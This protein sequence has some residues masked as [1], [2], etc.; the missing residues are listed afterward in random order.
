MLD[1]SDPA[2]CV[3]PV[4]PYMH[5]KYNNWKAESMFHLKEPYITLLLT[6]IHSSVNSDMTKQVTSLTN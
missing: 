2:A 6:Q 4:Y 5:N 3:Q 1:P